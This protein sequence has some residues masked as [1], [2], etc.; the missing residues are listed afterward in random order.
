MQ[1]ALATNEET[2]QWHVAKRR[3]T[4]EKLADGWQKSMAQAYGKLK[5]Q[6]R[7]YVEH[8][9]HVVKNIFKYKKTR[10]VAGIVEVDLIRVSLDGPAVARAQEVE[11]FGQRGFA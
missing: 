2:V 7:V 8:P 11:Q 4:I 5:A 6:V 10:Y 3:K 9:F 1:E